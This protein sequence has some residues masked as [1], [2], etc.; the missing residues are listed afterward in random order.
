MKNKY[1]VCPAEGELE[2]VTHANEAAATLPGGGRDAVETG[3]GAASHVR[4]AV[5]DHQLVGRLQLPLD[6]LTQ[7]RI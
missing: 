4:E 6:I 1:S 5:P 3:K 2:S 7:G